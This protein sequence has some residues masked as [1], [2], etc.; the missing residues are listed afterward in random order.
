M[1][2][3]SSLMLSG[4]PFRNCPAGSTFPMAMVSG[5]IWVIISAILMALPEMVGRGAR[6]QYGIYHLD[7]AVAAVMIN[8]KGNHP[9]GALPRSV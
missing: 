1:A 7:G 6:I 9:S 5:G 4:V 3:V 2:Q 8:N